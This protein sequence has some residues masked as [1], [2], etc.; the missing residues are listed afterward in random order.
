MNILKSL[1]R[2][3]WHV[4]PYLTALA[5]FFYYQWETDWERLKLA[6]A[7][8]HNLNLVLLLPVSAI[9]GIHIAI[10]R[11]ITATKQV[12]ATQ[13]GLL[14]QR[15]Q[16]AAEMLGSEALYSRLSGLRALAQLADEDDTFHLETMDVLATFVRHPPQ[17]ITQEDDANRAKPEQGSLLLPTREDIQAVMHYL[18]HRNSHHREIEW[19]NN[20]RLDLREAKLHTVQLQGANLSGADLSGAALG[21]RIR[22]GTVTIL[23]GRDNLWDYS[24]EVGAN[25]S[26]ADLSNAALKKALLLG[27]NLREATLCGAD[28]SGAELG[29]WDSTFGALFVANL[30][31]AN[32]SNADLREADLSRTNMEKANFSSANLHGALLH[33]AFLSG[34]NLDSVKNLTQEQL[35]SALAHPSQP[36]KLDNAFDPVTQKPLEWRGGEPRE[37]T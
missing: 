6:S 33:G 30:E 17:E 19:E 3:R 1:W 31:G 7:V 12:Q 20:Y 16:R 22:V 4:L 35:D 15:Y 14:N 2:A 26:G 5:L 32:M 34:T 24:D 21:T 9:I 29:S 13:R 23:P 10:W 25:L 8:L 36:P 18:G 28:L 37:N 11:G 27:T